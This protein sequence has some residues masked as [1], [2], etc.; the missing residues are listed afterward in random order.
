MG[1]QRG[2]KRV[3]ADPHHEEIERLHFEL[4]AFNKRIAELEKGHDQSPMIETLK[5]T[6]IILSR[7]IDE[8]RCS[9]ATERLAGLLAK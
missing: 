2:W 9:I 6:A 8:V 5:A 4:A 3:G 1:V 7:Q